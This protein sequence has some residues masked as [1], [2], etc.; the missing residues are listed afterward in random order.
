MCASA[1]IMVKILSID[2]GGTTGV[3]IISYEENIE[4]VI[5]YFEQIPGGLKGF[6]D[7]YKGAQEFLR[8]DVIVCESFTLRQS[9]KFPDLSPVYIIGALEA[10]WWPNDII[11]QSPSQKHLCD[12]GRL[13]IMGMHKPGKGHA[14]DAIR[15]G[16]IYLRNK[17]HL[18]TLKLG[19]TRE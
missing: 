19:W 14:N 13:K 5:Q 11:L 3:S 17:K 10:L 6:V 4:P 8:W 7:W 16:I 15:H 18:P 12:D 9:V 1:K 2:P